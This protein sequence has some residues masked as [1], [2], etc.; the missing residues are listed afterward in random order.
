M[1]WTWEISKPGLLDLLKKPITK[2][3]LTRLVDAESLVKIVFDASVLSL[4]LIERRLQVLRFH[5]QNIPWYGRIAAR[6]DKMIDVSLIGGEDIFIASQIV[7]V[8]FVFRHAQ[9]GQQ[10][11]RGPAGAIFA[12]GAMVQG[13]QLIFLA[14]FDK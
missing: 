11:G 10:C 13:R 14:Q 2:F 9:Q 5:T 1:H 3:L 12:R 4:D 7:F 6:G 8:H